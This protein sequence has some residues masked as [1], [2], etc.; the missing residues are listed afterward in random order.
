MKRSLFIALLA[1]LTAGPLFAHGFSGWRKSSTKHF[2]FVY[3]P[4]D[5][6]TVAELRSLA[7]GVYAKVTSFLESYP[8][9]IWVIVN[10]RVDTANGADFSLPSGI[11]LYVTSPSVP[12]LG[13]KEHDYL[14]M[15][16]THEL[17][18]Y[19]QF[20]Y[21]RG[22]Y[23]VLS[24]I[25]GSGVKPGDATF[26]PGWMIEGI[27]TNT[28][29]LFT[30]GGR[31]RD[32]YFELQ[33]KAL[34][35]DNDFF[36]L[37][38]AGYGSAFPPQSRIYLGGYLMVHYLLEHYGEKTYTKIH[39]QYVKFPFFGPWA[40][41]KKVTGRSAQEI[42]QDMLHN[43]RKKYSAYRKIAPGRTVSP[44]SAGNYYLPV[45]TSDGW[46]EYRDT[47]D[48]GPA[49]VRIDPK[50]GKQ[51][52]IVHTL[53]T[54]YTSLTAD[55]DGGKLV[56]S[57]FDVTPSPA[58]TQ[59][60]AVLYS[61][62]PATGKVERVTSQ[63]HLWQPAL[64]PDGNAL[65]AVQR[66]DSY[67]RLVA[68]DQKTGA[69]T[70]IF[71]EPHT[72]VFNP[73]FS[74]DGRHIA[75][76]LNDH[77]TQRI[78]IV[79]TEG[80]FGKAPRRDA[81]GSIN[82]SVAHPLPGAP[83]TNAYFPH[84][85]GDNAVTFSADLG[86]GLALYQTDIRDARLIRVAVDPVG[87]A[88]GLFDGNRILYSTYSGNGYVVK[89]RPAMRTPLAKTPM[90]AKKTAAPVPTTLPGATVG[91]GSRYI[92]WPRPLFWLPVPVY[93]YS[94]G[95]TGSI[96]FGFGIYGLAASLLG[97][98]QVGGMLTFRTDIFQ[99]SVVLNLQSVIGK[100]TLSYAAT[101]GYGASSAS[102]Y[103]QSLSQSLAFSIPLISSY[104]MNTTT[105][106]ALAPGVSDTLHVSRSQPF[107]FGQPFTS[108]DLFSIQ[109]G[110]SL[111]LGLTF[112]RRRSGGARDIFAPH[113][114]QLS[115]QG[116][117]APPLLSNA[118][119]GIT[120]VFTGTVTLPSFAAHQVFRLGLKSSLTSVSGSNA[121]VV[122]PRGLFLAAS[123]STPIDTQSTP[124]RTVLSLGYLST[125]TLADS[126]LPF[127]FNFQGLA[128]GVHIEAAADWSLSS[129]Q[130]T[131]DPYLY[132]GVELISLVG[133]YGDTPRLPIGFGLSIRFDPTFRHGFNP[134]SDIGPYFFVGTDSFSNPT[135]SIGSLGATRSLLPAATALTADPR[136]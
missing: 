23:A 18:H 42:Y 61:L 113:N 57:T 86:S 112:S 49:I 24:H 28:E 62:D 45:V 101:E 126:P 87:V 17:T 88:S 116:Q 93:T 16:L 7:E 22:F 2:V 67:S 90:E 34:V 74:P 129:A 121:P 82:R 56:F 96:P 122:N 114:L 102:T 119:S 1:L 59:Y 100:N 94:G 40:A 84:F 47:L 118:N 20:N 99:P 63:P 98:N 134:L 64:S 104:L 39:R 73:T 133:Y 66:V 80:L 117:Y 10:G 109:H 89:V 76:T 52:P 36:S 11:V 58:G 44:H 107:N 92:D 14:R 78:Y 54:D 60:D 6:A 115:L 4:R 27:T 136:R 8:E 13:F 5:Q 95:A 106:L 105:N 120:G 103:A 70:P 50:T 15:L 41:I 85:H 131:P 43:L 83:A 33:Y 46:F 108:P 55:A 75:F 32:P 65:V 26:L 21:D 3:E 51:T 97:R 53:L 12:I 111:D 77:G 72:N 69:V 37:D 48:S 38:K 91:T 68:V 124:G 25:L 110:Y 9:K 19:V 135:T 71:Y 128:A 127:G 81:T 123:T 35:L 132:A 79:R 125:V 30:H 31:G 130:L 29:T